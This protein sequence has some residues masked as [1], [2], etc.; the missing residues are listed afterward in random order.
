MLIAFRPT[1]HPDYS[2][3]VAHVAFWTAFAITRLYVRKATAAASPAENAP[4]VRDAVVARNS[5]LLVMAHAAGFAVMYMGIARGVF[6]GMKG[7]FAGQPLMGGAVIAAGSLLTIWALLYFKSWR[8]QAKL[9]P[10]HQLAT[11][12]P[13]RLLRHPIYMGI[14]LL[15]LGSALWIPNG[16]VWT[17]LVLMI[18]GGDLRGRAEERVLRSAF[19]Q[20]YIDY[21]SRTPRFIPGIY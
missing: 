19:G 18:I 3:Y 13:F 12:G 14:D 11:G 5:R 2:I 16:V 8:F 15:A 7:L 4:P 1:G 10:D 6:G 17:G 9:D 21:C 20:H